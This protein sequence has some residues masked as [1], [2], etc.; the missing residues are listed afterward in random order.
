MKILM[1]GRADEALAIFAKYHG[2]GDPNSPL[3]QLQYREIVEEYHACKDE[4]P[5]WD[6][7]ELGNTR[8][9]RYRLAMV[10]LMSFL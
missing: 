1:K 9:A 7:R 2:E 10:I 8:A 6:Y 4:N 3:V 5:W